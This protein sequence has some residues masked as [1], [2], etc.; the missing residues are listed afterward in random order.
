MTLAR[1]NC[2]EQ[3]EQAQTDHGVAEGRIPEVK[4]Q[5]SVDDTPYYHV[6]TRCVRRAFLYAYHP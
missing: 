4:Y 1:L 3:F 2:L 5:I 6:M